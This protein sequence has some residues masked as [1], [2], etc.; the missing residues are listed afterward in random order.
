MEAAAA[1]DVVPELSFGAPAVNDVVPE[2]TVSELKL[3]RTIFE[4]RLV[5]ENLSV[6]LN[7]HGNRVCR[8]RLREKLIASSCC[9]N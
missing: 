2:L 7:Q 1:N 3:L 5:G 4:G 9:T 6:V 8:L